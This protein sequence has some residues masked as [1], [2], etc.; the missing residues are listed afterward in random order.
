MIDPSIQRLNMIES[1]IRPS[2]ITDQGILRAMGAIRREDFVSPERR[3]L[4]YLDIDQPLVFPKQK[5]PPKRFL[6]APRTFAK[7]LQLA[8]VKSSHRVLDVGCG[9][10][11]SAAILAKLCQKVVALESDTIL[12]DVAS[13]IFKNHEIENISLVQGALPDGNLKEAPYDIIFLE[14]AISQSP[15]ILL[16]QLKDG[17]RMIGIQKKDYGGRAYQWIRTGEIVSSHPEFDIPHTF[18]LPG[19]EASRGFVF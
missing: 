1:Q 14:G 7:L 12:L 4:A 11:Y 6:M 17:G 18:I 2:D 15:K 9:T 19:F 13:Q 5:A 16:D 10:G 3:D 8:A